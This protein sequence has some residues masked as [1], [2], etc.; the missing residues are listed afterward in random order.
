MATERKKL[1]GQT[2]EVD[3]GDPKNVEILLMGFLQAL[4]NEQ[5]PPEKKISEKN[6]SD[7][8]REA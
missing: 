1:A 4:L 8:G 3:C 2:T 6:A 7:S 5:R